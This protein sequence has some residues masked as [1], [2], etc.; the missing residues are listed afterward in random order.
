MTIEQIRQ[1]LISEGVNLDDVLILPSDTGYSVWMKQYAPKYMVSTEE[2]RQH[3]VG[4]VKHVA[5]NVTKRFVLASEL[6]DDE[7]AQ[8]ATLY[9]KW[10]VGKAYVVGDVV[11]YHNV[12]YEVVQAHTSQADW[13]PDTVPALFKSH[14]PTGVIPE[15]VQPTGSH[16]AYN[17]GDKV[18]YE[19]KVYESLIDANTWSPIAYPQGWQEAV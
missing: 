8:I 18:T 3:D 9:D 13:T 2:I 16:D 11:S 5:Q 10:K 1:Q 7:L 4:V 14:A 19:G 15:W 6:T 17:T 12:L